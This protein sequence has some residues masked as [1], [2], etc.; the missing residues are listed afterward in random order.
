MATRVILGIVAVVA[1]R[2][3][4]QTRDGQLGSEDPLPGSSLD[5]DVEWA[6]FDELARLRRAIVVLPVLSIAAAI[7]LMWASGILAA[8]DPS[9][10]PWEP[11]RWAK[12][13]TPA[14][15]FDGPVWALTLSA[16][17]A[18]VV[19]ASVVAGLSA[20]PQGPGLA[21][22]ST[23][24]DDV[25]FAV[26]LFGSV[27]CWCIAFATPWEPAFAGHLLIESG[28]ALMLAVL[29]AL[30]GPT[31]HSARVSLLRARRRLEHVLQLQRAVGE[32]D[33][34]RHRL[35]DLPWVG[36][37]VACGG[38]VALDLPGILEKSAGRASVLELM[39]LLILTVAWITYLYWMGIHRHMPSQF[40][41]V[42]VNTL[43]VLVGMVFLLMA[44][45]ATIPAT[46]WSLASVFGTFLG[47]ALWRL[48]SGR[49]GHLVDR[50]SKVELA[51]ERC[52]LERL[53]KAM[54]ARHAVMAGAR[55]VR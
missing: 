18:A 39:R 36:V 54:H 23:V 11:L 26:S 10:R 44:V 6:E 47:P 12:E 19:L 42:L 35:A 34:G 8:P 48:N 22:R 38:V 29:G 55:Q 2:Q 14:A 25:A 4:L 20:A 27:A 24:L 7:Y 15:S 46:W 49:E 37:A 52:R 33:V 51:R 41:R 53:I 5:E 13:W 3:F 28:L 16:V 45:S 43:H 32:V 21:A 30:C 1:W 9:F 50:L 40:A 17:V 31:G